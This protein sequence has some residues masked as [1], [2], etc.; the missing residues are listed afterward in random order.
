M[1]GIYVEG[2]W[3]CSEMTSN[4]GRVS[5]MFQKL[6]CM[7]VVDMS[8]PVTCS[9]VHHEHMSLYDAS[10]FTVHVKGQC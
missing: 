3:C 4:A 2:P 8:K 5:A 9:P 10:R 7:A 1:D 6:M